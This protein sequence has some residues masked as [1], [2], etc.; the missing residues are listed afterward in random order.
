MSIFLSRLAISLLASAALTASAHAQ[1]LIQP[2]NAAPVA[3]NAAPTPAKPKPA[4]V[5]LSPDFLANPGL[6]LPVPPKPDSVE[7]K[8]ELAAV[9]A[10]QAAASP[11]R[12]ALATRDDK[13]ESVWLYSDVLPAGFTP[14]KLP[15]TAKLFE[16]ASNDQGIEANVFKPFFARIRP[17][18]VDHS[19]K[20]CVPS[21]YGKVPRSYPS[22]H[23]TL[24]YSLGIVLAHL[25]PEKAEIILSRAKVY[26]ESRVVCGVH[27]P[28]DAVAS[29]ALGTAIALEL[30]RNPAFKKDFD[31]AKAELVTAGL[32][33]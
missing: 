30:L 12:I 31:A 3:T 7:G 19:I 32:T 8:L 29:Q 33:K 28:S 25:M 6:I 17:F 26:G 9:K 15:L 22:G 21:T 18:D 2:T 20:T 11:E 14:E 16:A 27:F 24:G 4:L 23:T 1:V 10:V 5:Y 13:V